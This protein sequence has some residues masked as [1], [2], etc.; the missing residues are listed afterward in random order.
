MLVISDAE[1]G[2]VLFPTSPSAWFLI[3]AT[4]IALQILQ[5]GEAGEDWLRG[6]QEDHGIVRPDPKVRIVRDDLARRAVIEISINPSVLP[7][8]STQG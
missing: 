6:F 8:R 1:Q 4:L 5:G 2:E 3:L 7:T